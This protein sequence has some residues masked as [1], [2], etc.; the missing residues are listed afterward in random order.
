NPDAIPLETLSTYTR[1]WAAAQFGPE[2]AT[3]IAALL[4]GYT[5]L[6]ARRKPELIDPSTFS[7]IHDREAERVD[8]E[9]AELERRADAVRAALPKTADDAFF[10]L[11]WFPVKAS[12]NLT[13]L[14]IAAGRNRLYAAQG[15][16]GGA[17]AQADRVEA[18]FKRDAELTR[19]HDAIAG[20]KWVHMMDQTHIG[21]TS[22]QQP[23]RNIM[24]AV[25]RPSPPRLPLARIGV[26]I[27][28]REAAVTGAAELPVLHRYGAPSRWIDVFDT[29]FSTATFEVSTG[30]PWL[31]VVRGAPDPH[32]DARLEVSVDWARAP[33]G[34]ARAP[35]TIKGVTNIFTITAVISNPARQ[36][37]KG[38]FV[39]AGGVVAIEAEHHARATSADGVGW[40]TIPNLGRTLSGVV[41]YPTTAASSVPGKGAALEYLIDF[42]KAGPTDLTVFVSPS[43]DFR[44][45]RGLRYA[46]SIN[47]APPVTVNIIPDPS[48]RAWDKAV[49]DNIRRLTTR[50]E[51][52]S[53]GA[54]RVRLWR[55][56]PGVVFQR[57]VLSRAPPSGS[58]LGPVESVRR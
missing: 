34:L 3:Q 56:D 14:Y 52:P 39:E 5:K 54:H 46:V 45:N 30:A 42:E 26:A 35:I 12:A 1:D 24:P 6:N 49:A 18:L 40:K 10:Q 44:G 37:A 28:G 43:L 57:L 32:G 21:Y 17:Y 7:L 4:D 11:V 16:I 33:K 50:L 25:V 55:V 27:E 47:D 13:R 38:A 2:Q 15:R 8:A 20:G 41:A 48:E 19:Q 53:A 9:W 58:Y 36:P 29:G 51:I 22:W 23:D 31:K